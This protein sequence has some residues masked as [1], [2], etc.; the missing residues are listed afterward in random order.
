MSTPELPAP[1]GRIE[2]PGNLGEI[3][4][5]L[6]LVDAFTADQ[7]REM[8]RAGRLAGMEEAAEEAESFRSNDK[9]VNLTAHEIV[10]GEVAESIADAIRSLKE[11]QG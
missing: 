7:M 3:R 6:V 11:K 4:S 8:Y 2:K 10:T 9:A 5:R 1:A